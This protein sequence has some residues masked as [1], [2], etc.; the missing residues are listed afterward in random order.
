MKRLTA[1]AATLAFAAGP[2]LAQLPTER[3]MPLSL[4]LEAAQAALA[5]CHAKGY[6]TTAVV[7]IDRHGEEIVFLRNETANV[8]RVSRVVLRKAYTALDSRTPSSKVMTDM[9]ADAIAFARTAFINPN[10]TPQ[11]GGLPIMIGTDAVGAIAVAGTPGPAAADEGCA[12]AG[13]N[14]IKDRL[15]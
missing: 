13:L 15:K 1:L 6:D 8:T 12:Q 10:Y 7:V 2:A 9:Q 5:D 14:K 11:Q 4:A 3:V